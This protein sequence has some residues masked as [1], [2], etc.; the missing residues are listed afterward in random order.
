MHEFNQSTQEPRSHR[1]PVE[2]GHTAQNLGCS[3]RNPALTTLSRVFRPRSFATYLRRRA[4]LVV[5]GVRTSAETAYRALYRQQSLRRC[6]ADEM[7]AVSSNAGN[8]A[9]RWTANQIIV[10]INSVL[11]V[12]ESTLSGTPTYL[13]GV[14]HQRQFILAASTVV[15]NV[16]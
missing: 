6:G 13:F 3:T 9:V 1:S 12:R 10:W 2:G 16:S 8:S 5:Q 15:L 11:K 4:G 7:P 14:C